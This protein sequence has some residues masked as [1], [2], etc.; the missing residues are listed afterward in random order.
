MATFDELKNKG[1]ACFKEGQLEQ[2]IELYSKA[3]ELL[4]TGYI[5]LSNRSLAF[6]KLEKYELALEDADQCI[7]IC[8]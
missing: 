3:L 7:R 4:P 2:A 8:M 1:N 6:Y 5:A